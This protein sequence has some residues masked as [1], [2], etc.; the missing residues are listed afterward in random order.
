MKA[1][2]EAT[3]FQRRTEPDEGAFSVSV[4]QDWQLDG[5]ILRVDPNLE[6]TFTVTENL[7]PMAGGMWSSKETLFLRA[8]AQEFE[9]WQPVLSHIQIRETDQQIVEHRQR[10]NAEIQN[11]AFLTLTE[12]E[13][14]INPY[15]QEVDVGC[16]QWQYR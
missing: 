3:I 12:Q 6:K 8:P 15:T 5:G 9:Q 16:N 4:P 14:Y 7:G 2:V 1:N 10:T 13:K 11:D